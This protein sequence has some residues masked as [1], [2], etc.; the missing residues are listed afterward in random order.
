MTGR[1]AVIWDILLLLGRPLPNLFNLVLVRCMPLRPTQPLTWKNPSFSCCLFGQQTGKSGLC[2]Q[3][4]LQL[5][6]E[7]ERLQ[8]PGTSFSLLIIGNANEAL[9]YREEEI[10]F[11][12][13]SFKNH[14][15]GNQMEKRNPST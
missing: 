14:S 4:Y 3:P 10:L 15:I 11:R 8:S 12:S 9:N 6:A 2:L 5:D 1:D 7:L 13:L